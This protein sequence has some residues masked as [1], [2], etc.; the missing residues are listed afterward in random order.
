M[1]LIRLAIAVH[2]GCRLAPAGVS[3]TGHCQP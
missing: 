2:R 3:H 1:T